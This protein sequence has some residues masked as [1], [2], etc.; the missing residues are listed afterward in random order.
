MRV[1]ASRGPLTGKRSCSP[2]TF[3]YAMEQEMRMR[4]RVLGKAPNRIVALLVQAAVIA[5]L[6]GI[7]VPPARATGRCG[8]RMAG[9]RQPVS[10]DTRCQRQDPDATAA[11]A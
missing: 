6:I 4:F 9:A 1:T 2:R 10:L 11:T 5:A 8:T 3:A 7:G